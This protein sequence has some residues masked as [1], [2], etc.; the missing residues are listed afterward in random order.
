MLLGVVCELNFLL[1][2]SERSKNTMYPQRL[3]DYDGEDNL[4]RVVDVFVDELD[5]GVLCFRGVE[6]L[7]M[8]RLSCYQ[9]AEIPRVLR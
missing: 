7:A 3:E 1:V 6:P 2:Q 9:L 5:L 4:V 8:G